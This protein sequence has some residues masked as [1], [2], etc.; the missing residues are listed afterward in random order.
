VTVNARNQ[1][2][3]K[4]FICYSEIDGNVALEIYEILR[5]FEWAIPWMTLEDILPGQLRE[6]EIEKSIEEAHITLILLSKKAFESNGEINQLREIRL[7]LDK[8]LGRLDHEVS[9]IPV[10]LDGINPQNYLGRIGDDLTQRVW[11]DFRSDNAKNQLKTIIKYIANEMGI[12]TM[13]RIKVFI[14]YSTVNLEYAVKIY[15]MLETYHWISPWI[16]VENIQPGQNWQIEIEKAINEADITLV[17]LS[18]K[19][20][21]KNEYTYTFNEIRQVLEKMKG[22]DDD[23]VNLLPILVDGKNPKAY[24]SPNLANKFV[25]KQW[26]DLSQDD[27]EKQ[28]EKILRVLEQVSINKQE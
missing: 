28:F 21:G 3:I 4:I 6:Q 2:K 26:I 24:L 5:K 27:L 13:D 18:E 20:F 12:N 23:I 17:L 25:E 7:I 14:C 1:R 19:A 9:I 10:I 15:K 11:L 16:A 22:F 8:A